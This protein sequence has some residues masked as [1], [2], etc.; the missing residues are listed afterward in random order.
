MTTKKILII[1]GHP[2]DESFN[3]ALAEAYK[4]GAVS[5]GG[6]VREL[7]LRELH[8]N[9]NLEYGYSKRSEL[10]PD[11]LRAQDLIRWANHLVWIFPVWWGSVP[12]LLKGFLDR[13]FL[14]GFAYQKRDNSLILD[15]LLTGKT[16]RIISTIDQPAWYYRLVYARPTFH[17]MKKLTLELC[18]IQPVKTTMIG[19]IRLSKESFRASWLRRVEQLGISHR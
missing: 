6:E 17:A 9:L 18:G 14:P 7:R 5:S 3:A 16:A 2:N 4:Q 11:L 1:N 15:G 13:T 19:P 12:A 10:E 8:F